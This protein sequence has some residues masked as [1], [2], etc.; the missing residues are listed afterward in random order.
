[1]VAR[2]PYERGECVRRP[3]ALK[4]R[5]AVRRTRW[6]PRVGGGLARLRAQGYRRHNH[7]DDTQHGS[8]VMVLPPV[9]SVMSGRTAAILRLPEVDL[10]HCR[11]PNPSSLSAARPGVTTGMRSHVRFARGLRG[12]FRLGLT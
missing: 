4:I 9:V 2:G 6:P 10:C 5:M 12:H 7:T 3:D 8:H 1:S 11:R